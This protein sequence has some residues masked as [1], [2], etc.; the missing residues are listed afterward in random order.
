M[1]GGWGISALDGLEDGYLQALGAVAFMVAE[2]EVVERLPAAAAGLSEVGTW[3]LPG[4]VEPRGR[5]L[6]ASRLKLQNVAR[7]ATWRRLDLRDTASPP[8]DVGAAP[9]R[10]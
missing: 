1:D 6:R 8:D 7:P 3:S 2:L 10:P 9:V 4:V 5:I